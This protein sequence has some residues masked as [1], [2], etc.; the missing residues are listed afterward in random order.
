MGH[1]LFDVYFEKDFFDKIFDMLLPKSKYGEEQNGVANF[2]KDVYKPVCDKE[3]KSMFFCKKLYEQ[4]FRENF[5][6]T[7]IV[8]NQEEPNVSHEA[9]S[10]VSP[11][12]QFAPVENLNS[13]E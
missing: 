13:M 12:S 4:K 9:S 5:F 10:S 3:Y 11:E 7:R 2:W 6:T 8:Q 1:E